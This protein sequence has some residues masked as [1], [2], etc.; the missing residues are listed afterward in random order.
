M[1]SNI[2]INKFRIEKNLF[3]S[4]NENDFINIFENIFRFLFLIKEFIED[5]S[6]K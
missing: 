4:L 5:L 3:K 2:L 6:V 1:K